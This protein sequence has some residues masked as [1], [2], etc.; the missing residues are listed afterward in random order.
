MNQDEKQTR[1]MAQELRKTL[2]KMKRAQLEIQ[3]TQNKIVQIA[4]RTDIVLPEHLHDDIKNN[5][6]ALARTQRLLL[7][8][9]RLIKNPNNKNASSELEKLM[10]EIPS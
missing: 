10:E 9:G 7:V 5:D 6:E 2:H 3:H 1:K 4:G 8:C